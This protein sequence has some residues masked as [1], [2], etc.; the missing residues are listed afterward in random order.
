MSSALIMQRSVAQLQ[1]DVSMSNLKKKDIKEALPKD[2]EYKKHDGNGLFLRVRPS[3]AKSW[4]YIFS[5]PGERRLTK[6]TLG[7][8]KDVSIESARQQVIELKKYVA[9]GIDPRSAKAAA[10]AENA[11]AITMQKLFENWIDFEKSADRVTVKWMKSHEDRWRLHLKSSLGKLLARDIARVHLAAVLDAM[12][13]K[14]IREET[15]KAL[16]TLNLMLDYGL[17]RNLVEQNPARTLRPKDFAATAARPRDRVL[18]LAELKQLWLVLD[19]ASSTSLSLVIT[20]AIKLLMLT[21]A[22]RGEVAAMQWSELDLDHGVW[23]LPSERT[24][25]RQSHR[26]YLSNLAISL[27]QALIPISGQTP[28]VFCSARGSSARHIHA[29]T[30]TGAIAKLRGLSSGSKKKKEQSS[31]L[32]IDSFSIHDLRRSA[33][34]GWGEHLKT[35]PHVIERMLNHQPLNK[36]IATYQRAVYAKE[37]KIAWHSWS[38]II[39]GFNVID[40]S[41]VI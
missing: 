3:G 4:V 17:T 27:I 13:R 40:G 5:L 19:Q 15:R 30:L 33:A 9:S 23:I 41:D 38:E 6:M 16:T 8:I 22:R 32:E 28:F 11:Q 1:L 14:G 18:S 36:L 20:T 7:S 25:N 10:I 31:L 35:E 26:I 37:Q 29:D 21:G 34:T 24:K 39:A 2:K 12:M